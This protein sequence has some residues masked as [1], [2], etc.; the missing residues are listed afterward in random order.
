MR[1]LINKLFSHLSLIGK[2]LLQTKIFFI[3]AVILVVFYLANYSFIN[4]DHSNLG[5]SFSHL[6][7]STIKFTNN[8]LNDGVINDKFTMLE[9]P[10]SIESKTINDREPYISY[11]SGTILV[12]YGIAKTFGYSQ[13]D[14]AFVKNV[15]TTLYALDALLIGILF[16]LI[17]QY[18]FKMKSTIGKIILPALLSSLWIVLPSNT[19]YLKNVFFA[20][21]LVLFFIYL[22]LV[23]ELLK[24]YADI[25]KSKSKKVIDILLFMTIVLGIL[26][27][28][29]F[30]IQLFVLCLIN[31]FTPLLQK[32]TFI[33]SVKSIALYLIA[34]LLGV[35]LYFIQLIQ[36]ENW[37]FILSDKAK[38]RMGF[39]E[40]L[41]DKS[42]IEVLIE[43]ITVAYDFSGL[44]F[45]GIFTSCLILLICLNVF[46]KR[47]AQKKRLKDNFLIFSLLIILPPYLQLFALNNHAVGHEFSILKLGLPFVF[48]FL[49][50]AYTI[51]VLYKQPVHLD[52]EIELKEKNCRK[53]LNS[54]ALLVVILV[55]GFLLSSRFSQHR[56]LYSM[57]RSYSQSYDMELVVNSMNRYENVFFSYTDSIPTNPP[58]SL[59]IAKK[60][61]YKIEKLTDIK[62]QFPDLDNKAVVLVLINENAQKS[63]EIEE[64]EN[65]VMKNFQ[66]VKREGNYVIYQIQ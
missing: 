22:L 51:F 45:F 24:N 31:F 47:M 63:E 59:A 32:K 6:T 21:Q 50:V 27:D 61:V 42:L 5:G 7:G 56:Y 16:F 8:W 14:A 4:N 37:W 34:A 2:S 62:D 1:K 64:E 58:Q 23:L 52:L 60:M 18:L 26:T 39:A 49:L 36:I 38:F 44:L 65:Y 15:N 17:L 33:H 25:K 46:K 48:G 35:G 57:Y 3:S 12:T 43:R 20:D 29:Y 10:L 66:Q 30:W 19:Y 41:S 28:Y 55:I 40:S 13:V 54:Y 53:N 9:K 11:P